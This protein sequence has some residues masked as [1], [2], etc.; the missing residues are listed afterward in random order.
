M[1]MAAEELPDDVD[2]LKVIVV[3]LAEK[4][5]L[6]EDQ[7]ARNMRL[8]AERIEAADTRVEVAEARTKAADERIATLTAIVKMLERLRYG[9]RSERLGIPG[10]TDEQCAFVVRGE[11]E[12]R[13]RG[14]CRSGSCRPRSCE[15]RAAP[16]QGVFRPS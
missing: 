2:A 8:T 15:A 9:R 5:A 1:A 14:G 7:A 13:R 4:A 10:L 11:R 12:R 3:A 16:A 6:L